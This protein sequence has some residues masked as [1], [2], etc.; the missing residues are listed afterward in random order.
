M[1]GVASW[2]VF[3]DN[4]TMLD[5][6]LQ[7]YK[8]GRGNGRLEH[9]VYASGQSQ[10]S[11]RD[12]NHA[13]LGLAKLTETALTLYHALNTTEPFT[14]ADHRLRTG[15]EYTA[16]FNLG[17]EVPFVANGGCPNCSSCAKVYKGDWCF[18]TISNRSSCEMLDF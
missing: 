18:K 14:H 1:S 11:G 2:A 7:Y 17:R 10:E 13:Q 15:L 12:Q 5:T 9:Y 6:V 3:L 4:A 16:K 8:A